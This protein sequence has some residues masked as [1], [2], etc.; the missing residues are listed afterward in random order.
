MSQEFSTPKPFALFDSNNTSW[1]RVVGTPFQARAPGFL[2]RPVP[3]YHS[4]TKAPSP[5][6]NSSTPEQQLEAIT[7]FI[8]TTTRL[9]T[10]QLQWLALLERPIE[11]TEH[12]DLEMQIEKTVNTNELLLAEAV[13]GLTMQGKPLKIG[14]PKTGQSVPVI[15]MRYSNEQLGYEV[16]IP[17]SAPEPP[18]LVP[19]FTSD[20]LHL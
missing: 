5:D 10:I 15:G 19:L 16:A 20:Q 12:H 4:A 9:S 7:E 14:H 11:T 2:S 1:P 6:N 18:M 3:N 8:N 13:I 17:E